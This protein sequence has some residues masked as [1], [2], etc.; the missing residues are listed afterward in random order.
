MFQ[1]TSISNKSAELEQ[2]ETSIQSITKYLVTAAESDLRLPKTWVLKLMFNFNINS[3]RFLQQWSRI[4]IFDH[5]LLA[6]ISE[7]LWRTPSFI[8]SIKLQPS[9]LF[10]ILKLLFLILTQTRTDAPPTKK[11]YE[12]WWGLC[13][14]WIPSSFNFNTSTKEKRALFLFWLLGIKRS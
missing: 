1:Q 14:C 12:I 4:T 3:N 6:S 13:L 5:M 2:P 8:T 7:F 9:H 11:L 10:H